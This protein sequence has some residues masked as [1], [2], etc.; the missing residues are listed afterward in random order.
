ME[1]VSRHHVHNCTSLDSRNVLLQE[2]S[3]F[4]L[5]LNVPAPPV[6]VVNGHPLYHS[7]QGLYI[8]TPNGGSV[9]VTLQRPA[10]LSP[11]CHKRR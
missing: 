11:R 6:G 8:G 3:L 4:K 2:T 5:E 7:V 1:R 10:V 9:G